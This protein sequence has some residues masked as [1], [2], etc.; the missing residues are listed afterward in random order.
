MEKVLIR[1]LMDKHLSGNLV[2]NLNIMKKI[3]YIFLIALFYNCSS[4]DHTSLSPINEYLNSKIKSKDTII[5]IQNKI[6]NNYTLNLLKERST[7]PY[8]HNMTENSIGLKDSL[9]NEN[10]WNLFNEKY[11][12]ESNEIWLDSDLWKNNYFV[13]KEIKF[14]PEKKFPKPYILNKYLSTE[15]Y[16]YQVFSF[17]EPIIYRNE[18][19]IFSKSETTTRKQFINPNS[20]IV[21]KKTKNKW[22]FFQEITDGEYY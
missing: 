19:A 2:I 13:K 22:I 1:L 7:I 21:M 16:E 9:Y 4:I 14:V 15:M 8:N 10:D 6:N 12:I 18:Y 20:I 17:S 3:I 11:R 5:I